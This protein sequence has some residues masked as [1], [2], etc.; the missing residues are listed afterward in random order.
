LRNRKRP[1]PVASTVAFF[2]VP[3][4]QLATVLPRNVR[5]GERER[6]EQ[7]TASITAQGVPLE[8][9]QRVA[10]FDLLPSALDVAELADKYRVDPEHVASLYC[11]VGDRLRFDWLADR[12]AELP[13]E[14]RWDALARNA[15]RE[16]VAG[17]HRAVVDAILASV[18]PGF[19]AETAYDVWAGSRH[20]AVARALQLID[21]MGAA[22]LADLATLSVV[23][24]ELRSLA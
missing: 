1:L 15:L 4:A 24:R 5:G 11:V 6:I 7:M 10:T 17:E 18:D 20:D 14:Q 16:D 3:V 2:A 12:V 22:G 23:I 9:A 21:D 8:L 13:R 19:E